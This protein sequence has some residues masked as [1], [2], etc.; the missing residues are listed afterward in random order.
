MIK[1]KIFTIST[2]FI[3]AVGLALSGCSSGTGDGTTSGTTTTTTTT[4]TDVVGAVTVAALSIAERVSVI[5]ANSSASS[6]PKAKAFKA[7]TDNLALGAVADLAATSDYNT[8]PQF[9]WVEERSTGAFDSV[10][11]ILCYISQTKYDSFVNRGAYIAQVDT[12]KCDSGRDSAGGGESSQ[13]QSSGSNAATYEYWTVNVTRADATSPMYFN[14]WVNQNQ[15]G[16]GGGTMESQILIRGAVTASAA[17]SPPYGLFTMNFIGH[18]KNADGSLDTANILFKGFLNSVLDAA[19]DASIEFGQK[20]GQT[21]GGGSELATLYRAVDGTTG[22]GTVAFEERFGPEGGST[23]AAALFDFAFDADSFKRQKQDGTES[24][25]LSRTT[26][27][28]TVWR[29][30]LYNDEN[31]ATDPGGRLAINSGMPILY[32]D[33]ATD[34]YGWVGFWGLWFPDDVTLTTGTTVSKLEWGNAGQTTSTDYSVFISGGKLKKHTKQTVTLGDLVGVPLSWWGCTGTYP[35][36]VCGEYR[37]EWDGTD[38]VKT[39]QRDNTTWVW[40][41]L[42]PTVALIETDFTGQWDFW[43]WSE[44]LRGNGRFPLRTSDGTTY[45]VPAT[46]T[47]V[48]FYLEEMIYPGDA[49]VPASLVCFENCPDPARINGDLSASFP[50][51]TWEVQPNIHL[52]TGVAPAASTNYTYTYD[53]NAMTLTEDSSGSSVVQ[54]SANSAIE[55]GIWTGP[56]FDLNASDYDDDN[57]INTPNL[58]NLAALACD[59]D[60]SSTCAWQA[61]DRLSSYYTWETGMEPWSKFTVLKDAS[62]VFVTFDPP[63][64]VEYTNASSVKFYLEYGGVGD[65]WGIPGKCVDENGADADCNDW[66]TGFIRWVP[67]FNIPDGTPV[68]NAAD[69]T[70][71]YY[72][73]AMEKEQRMTD[74]GVGCTITDTIT[75]YTLPDP[76]TTWVDPAIGGEPAVTDPPAVVGGEVQRT[77]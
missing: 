14:V 33:G 73:K 53:T 48:T 13:N 60:T 20:M 22:S 51:S 56:M 57:D 16:P 63:I 37:V 8:D 43:F 12:S 61:Q 5:D 71:I 17:D 44:A 70:T 54:T 74:A 40:V 28:S 18:P 7:L 30:S 39:A 11:E 26:F 6:S 50:D 66:T 67:E 62:D 77:L 46:G 19:G 65:L 35:N 72:V 32:N 10:N 64:T 9:V 23:E 4:G 52:Q 58:T 59:W 75:S 49:T 42:S 15:E 1:R 41:D 69:G 34:Y 27:D 36:D 68:T 55:W 25:C 2:A 47:V 3:V 31:H 38:L 21:F 29:Y 24:V 45:L 76:E